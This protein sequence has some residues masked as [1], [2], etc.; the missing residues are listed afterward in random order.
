MFSTD[1]LP[2]RIEEKLT[3][4]VDSVVKSWEWPV[5][6]IFQSFANVEWCLLRTETVYFAIMN[7]R[8][9]INSS[10]DR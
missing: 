10:R 5:D 3:E 4:F 6:F 9:G 8:W 1:R 2:E 7:E